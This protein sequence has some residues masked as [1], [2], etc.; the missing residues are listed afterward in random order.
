MGVREIGACTMVFFDATGTRKRVVILCAIAALFVVG[1]YTGLATWAL[2]SAR[3]D[4][5]PTYASHSGEEAYARTIALTFDDGPDPVYTHALMDLLLEHDVPAAFFL[6]GSNVVKHPDIARAIVENGFEI[7]NHTFTHSADMAASETRL[8]NEL[9]TTDRVIREHTGVTARLFRPP[10]LEDIN[11]GEF[12]GGKI[13]SEET[14][15]AE[16][17]GF[18]VVG[19]TL[20]T[21]D[22]DVSPGS[23][24]VILE[25]LHARIEPSRPV[26]IIMHE[27]AGRGATIEALREFIPAMKEAGYTFVPISEYFGLSRSDIMSP[28]APLSL[29]DSFII[30]ST[31]LLVHGSSIFTSII[32]ILSVLGL[33]RITTLLVTRRLVVPYVR[34]GW[35]PSIAQSIVSIPTHYGILRAA[36][37][38]LRYAPVTVL[39]PAYNEAAN[40][41][42]TILSVMSGS[43]VPEQ[44][45]VIDDGS[46]DD[47]PLV[48]ERIAKDYGERLQVIRRDNSGSKAGALNSALPLVRHDI[49]IAIDADTI[50][51]SD[52]VSYLAAHFGDPQVGAVAGKVYPASMNSIYAQ[53]QYLE[54]MQGQNIDKQVFAIGNSIAV[55]PGAIGAWRVSALEAAGGYSTDT[56]VEDQDL[57]L[58]LLERGFR[59]EFEPRAVAY[60]ETPNT[61]GAFF[62]QRSRWVFGTLQCAWKY[63]AHLFSRSRPTLGWIVLPNTLIFNLIIPALIPIVDGLLILGLFGFIDLTAAITPFLLYTALDMWYAIEGVANERHASLKLVSIVIW[64]RFFYRYIIAAAIYRGLVRAAVGELVG[65]G[66]HIRR[67]D[68]HHVLSEA[69]QGV[70]RESPLSVPH[71]QPTSA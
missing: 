15:W 18:I 52:A 49:V 21:Q 32:F 71:V 68:C 38:G 31:R 63:R 42:A 29:L 57:T 12:D 39:I 51:G 56:V 9:V 7:G 40:I 44:V 10:F 17:A 11:V 20:D 4:P 27:H 66:V 28:A 35:V 24:D 67:G 37:P 70:P 3:T 61:A 64:Q 13:G 16:K 1:I 65:W 58:A 62:R 8:R 43:A 60:T 69:L 30:S 5:L 46:T 26:V 23:S 2:Q 25:R 6:I 50:I 14:R 54:Y 55:V 45:I 59:V 36:W 34:R 47:T 41:E 33:A 48:L 19:G 53:F 22:W